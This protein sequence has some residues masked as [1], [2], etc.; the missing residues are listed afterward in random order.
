MP[1]IPPINAGALKVTFPANLPRNEKDLI[2]ML[3]AGRL[4]DLWKGKLICAQLA[5]DDLI[6][7]T[8][9]VSGLSTLRT[10]LVDL[11]RSMNEF[12]NYSGYDRIL[13]GVNLALGQISNV[14]SLGG[15]CPSPVQAPKI[16]D[17]LG[18]LNQN[19][20]GQGMN[21]LNALVQ[22]SNPKVCFGGGPK[23]FGLDWSQ[24]DGSLKRLKTAIKDFKTSPGNYQRVMGAFENNLNIQRKRLNAEIT[25]L[26]K[27]LTD[28]LGVNDKKNTVAAITRV[29]Q[30]SDGFPVKDKFGVKY[31]TPTTMMISGEINSVLARTDP[32]YSNPVKYQTVP[33]VDY[34]GDI[35]GYER[36][37]ITGD[38]NYIGWDTL[39]TEL[40]TNNPTI[41]P[42][43]GF[44]H[45]NFTFKEEN[46]RVNIYDNRGLPV[47]NIAIERGKHYKIGL[48]LITAS[49]AIYAASGPGSG[50]IWT[51]GV[52]IVKEPDYGI[53]FEHIDPTPQQYFNSAAVEADWMVQI[54]EPT[55]PNSLSWAATTGQSGHISVSGITQLPEEDKTYDTSMAYKKSWLYL[56]DKRLSYNDDNPNS[57]VDYQELYTK[58]VYN[59]TVNITNSEGI[60]YYNLGELRYGQSGSAGG[61]IKGGYIVRDDTETLN[62]S[63]LFDE[64]NKI[65]EINFALNNNKTLII[66][67]YV[68]ELNGFEVYQIHSYLIDTVNPDEDKIILL[69]SL[70]FDENFIFLSDIKLP[71][72]DFCDYNLTL[73]NY[74]GKLSNREESEIKIVKTGTELDRIVTNITPN[75][76]IADVGVNEFIFT[77]E[78][79]VHTYDA[80]RM[81]LFT[82][83]WEQRMFMYFRG[84]N[85]FTFQVEM[86]YA[87]DLP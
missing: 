61:A 39:N 27:N 74:R 17:V 72:T 25:R 50:Q 58:R 15:L 9:G 76:T 55:T 63:A 41:F 29:K 19:L 65:V 34:C 32:L 77:S 10:A 40:N 20:F 44:E 64:G 83:P 11:K 84:E 6:K 52:K 21:I 60:D 33:V 54:E 82:N 43:P 13:S 53:G 62:D 2:C 46:G 85:N 7:D 57:Y 31:D 59:M 3:L 48:Q 23:G 78:I 80:D 56:I 5:I 1:S 70:R 35:T 26:G 36:K 37:V 49:V 71:Y 73:N 81:Y 47:E 79:N 66:K 4:K 30:T 87:Y 51:E 45:Y 14:F 38:P 69:S 68:N 12:K 28:P 18:T 22:A 24:V 16:P 42:Q 75:R 86:V 8:T 67:K